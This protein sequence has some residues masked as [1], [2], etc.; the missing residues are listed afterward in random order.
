MKRSAFA[1]RIKPLSGILRTAH[2]ASAD[3]PRLRS[4]RKS[5]PAHEL[6]YLKRVAAL[7]CVECGIWGYSQAA[8]SNRYQDG[9]G[10]G[11]KANYLATFPMCCTRPDEIGCHVRHDQLIGITREEADVRTDRYIADTQKKLRNP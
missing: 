3:K 6:A 2:L 9:K 10:R 4:K 5:I 11:I 7:P 8:H 1:P